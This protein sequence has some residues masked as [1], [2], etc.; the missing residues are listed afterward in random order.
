E[1]LKRRL[2]FDGL[3]VGDWNGHE[4]VDGC[5]QD[6]CPQAV[7]AG[8]DIF[9]VPD[10]WRALHANTVAQVQSGEISTARLDD[11]VRRILRVKFRAGLFAK[12]Q[13]SDREHAGQ[14]EL[15]GAPEHRVVA[16]Q[17]VRESLV[18]L[19]NRSQLLPL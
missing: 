1:V 16:R 14:G 18:L 19:K 5:R 9:M 4:F 3:I 15:I 17:A 8:L 10:Q 13:P 6:S 2:G 7:N 11:A 12:G